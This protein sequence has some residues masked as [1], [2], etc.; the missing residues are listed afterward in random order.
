MLPV[1][2]RNPCNYKFLVMLHCKKTSSQG[3]PIIQNILTLRERKQGGHHDFE[4]ELGTLAMQPQIE[5]LEG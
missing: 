5:L 2:V 3:A 1:P 4:T